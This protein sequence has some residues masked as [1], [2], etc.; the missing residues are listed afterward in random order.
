MEVDGWT[1][2]RDAKESCKLREEP[3]GDRE[4][5]KEGGQEDRCRNKCVQR[6][7]MGK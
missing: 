3:E 7:Q 4:E 2:I 1:E 6:G 5:G